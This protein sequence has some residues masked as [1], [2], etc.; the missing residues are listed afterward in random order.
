MT[1]EERDDFLLSEKNPSLMIPIA[2]ARRIRQ[3]TGEKSPQERHLKAIEAQIQVFWDLMLRQSE[4]GGGVSYKA[5]EELVRA[6]PIA[7]RGSAPPPPGCLWLPAGLGLDR[8]TRLLFRP[9]FATCCDS[10]VC[11]CSI[12]GS[13]RASRP[14]SRRR[15]R[16]KS[17]A[18]TGRSTPSARRAKV[19]RPK[20]C[21]LVDGHCPPVETHGPIPPGSEDQDDPLVRIKQRFRS[22]AY[23]I[24][25]ADWIKLFKAYD[26]DGNGELRRR[27]A[28][29]RFALH[30][31]LASHT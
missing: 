27:Q 22:A 10:T 24:N 6:L 13:P 1:M 31:S 20:P 12:C 11:W 14:L 23:T 3:Q 26:K 15:R 28:H 16:K 8:R 7:A 5:Y 21:R 30:T 17:P 18:T 29:C 25:G 2:T 9:P 4:I 19:R